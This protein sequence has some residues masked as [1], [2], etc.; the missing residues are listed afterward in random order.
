[1]FNFVKHS[2]FENTITVFIG[3]NTLVMAIRHDG[4]PLSMSRTLEYLNYVF[5][6]IFN[7][8]MIMKLIG[9]G[10]KQYFDDSWNMFDAF[11]VIATDVGLVLNFLSAGSS[12]S[13]A[14]TVVRAF[15]IMRIIR[16]VRKS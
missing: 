8:E 13:T 6:F 5:A 9:L 14:A 16:L 2:I 15:R 3:L 4:M 7:A 12:F 10:Y 1:M 11:V